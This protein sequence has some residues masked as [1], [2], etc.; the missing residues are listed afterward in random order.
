MA[1]CWK[2][3]SP[4]VPEKPEGPHG[5]HLRDCIKF[6]G[7]HYYPRLIKSVPLASLFFFSC[8]ISSIPLAYQIKDLRQ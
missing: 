5:L 8:E 6:L 2:S 1:S 4:S 3:H 7:Y